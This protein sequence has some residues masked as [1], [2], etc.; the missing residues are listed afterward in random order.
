VNELICFQF[1]K[2]SHPDWPCPTD[3]P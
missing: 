3:V 1:P 2:N